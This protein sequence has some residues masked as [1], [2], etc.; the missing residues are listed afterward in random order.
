M[1]PDRE[2]SKNAITVRNVDENDYAAVIRLMDLMNRLH[3]EAV[4]HLMKP[5]K[6]P[7][8]TQQGFANILA[9]AK[10]R[11]IVACDGSYVCGYASLRLIDPQ[12]ERTF[13]FID[14]KRVHV[15]EIITDVGYRN[16]GVGKALMATAEAW[17][18]E[19]GATKM[20]LNVFNFNTPAMKFYDNLGFQFLTTAMEKLV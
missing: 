20:T 6:I 10:Q 18:R 14:S 1:G 19:V 4:P 3:Y 16:C 15:D 7:F 17:T 11:L 5:N 8:F 12:H 2:N 9:D 13:P